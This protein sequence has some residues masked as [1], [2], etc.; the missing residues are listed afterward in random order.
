MKASMA[1]ALATLAL[2][3]CAGQATQP[4]PTFQSDDEGLDCPA[5]NAEISSN[6]QRIEELGR[7]GTE[8][9]TL[10]DR[11]SHLDTL[12]AQRHCGGGQ[13]SP[14]APPEHN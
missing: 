13:Q 10:Q 3:A 1:V 11:Q 2:A 4:L 9:R 8:A 14:T 7:E 5:I 6:N 12:F